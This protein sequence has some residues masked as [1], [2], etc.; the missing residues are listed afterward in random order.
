M[1]L[2]TEWNLHFGTPVFACFEEGNTHARIILQ[3]ARFTTNHRGV[4]KG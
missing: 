3:F 2:V 4:T 1:F